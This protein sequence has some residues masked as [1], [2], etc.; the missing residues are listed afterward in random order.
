MRQDA[1]SE[2]RAAATILLAA[3]RPDVVIEN[4]PEV[5]KVKRGKKRHVTGIKFRD[6]VGRTL[7]PK[8]TIGNNV[9]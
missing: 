1:T 9:M 2:E 4:K 8:I 3:N 6:A 7:H 5:K